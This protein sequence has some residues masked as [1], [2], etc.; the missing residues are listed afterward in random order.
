MRATVFTDGALTRQA[1]RFVWLAMDTE[2]AANA[3]FRTKFSVE[4]LPTFFVVDPSTESR[5]L[6]WVGGA[7]VPQLAKILDDGAR[8]VNRSGSA[9][10]RDL[11]AAD[12]LF[13]AGKNKEAVTAYQALL[14]KAPKG[15]KSFGRTT[16]SLIFALTATRDFESCAATA[17]DAFPALAKTSSPANVAGSGLS[18]VLELPAENAKRA[19]LKDALLAA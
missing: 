7:T 11:A 1:G 18:C 14:G 8:A 3:W 13:A 19:A 12:K 17:R 6:R 9:L 16:E 4:A 10:D 15:W 2:K 5:A